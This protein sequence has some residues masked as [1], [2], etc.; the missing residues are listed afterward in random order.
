MEAD[1]N[2]LIRM[3][4]Y[5][6]VAHGDAEIAGEFDGEPVF[7][8][9]DAGRERAE[10]IIDAAIRHH[11]HLAAEALSEALGVSLEVGEGL[12]ALRQKSMLNLSD[13]LDGF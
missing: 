3:A 11:G 6:A 2:Y 4:A 12:V 10:A 7:K 9:T 8:L 5:E 13:E 1:T